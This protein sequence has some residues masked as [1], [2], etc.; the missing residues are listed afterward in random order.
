MIKCIEDFEVPPALLYFSM[1]LISFMFSQLEN[2]NQ[3]QSQ[4]PKQDPHLVPKS[5]KI[6]M[7][8]N[9]DM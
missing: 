9:D 3:K 5:R 7:N 4:Y 2:Q 8:T 1:N 6:F